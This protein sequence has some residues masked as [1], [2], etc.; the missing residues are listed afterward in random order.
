MRSHGSPVPSMRPC[1]MSERVRSVFTAIVNLA[2]R[3]PWLVVFVA[4]LMGSAC[5]W[6]GS[7]L[8]AHTDF[9]DLV[10]KDT[11]GYQAYERQLGRVGGGAS[12][13]V[14]VDSPDKLANEKYIDDVYEKL[15]S[16]ANE[17]ETCVKVCGADAACK[18]KCGP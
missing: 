3:S 18:A 7:H 17:H 6:Y 4:L 8:E 14:V 16:M 12:L 15:A 2:N 9:L 11:P 1:P 5:W 10:P 13:I